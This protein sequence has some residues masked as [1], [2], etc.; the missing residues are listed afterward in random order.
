MPERFQDYVTMARFAGVDVDK[1]ELFWKAQRR[2]A[3]Y[4]QGIEL[5]YEPLPEGGP[6][7]SIL[8][9][10]QQGHAFCNSGFILGSMKVRICLTAL[11]DIFSFDGMNI[12]KMW[13]FALV[14]VRA[15][16]LAHHH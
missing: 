14:F 7:L 2:Y 9:I 15:R 10:D 5:P 6:A 16:S 8:L 13:R 11:F 4:D 12:A 3:A 1:N